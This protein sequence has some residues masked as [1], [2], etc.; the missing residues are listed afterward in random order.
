MSWILTVLGGLALG[1]VATLD[2]W[3]LGS[4]SMPGWSLP[5]LGAIFTAGLIVAEVLD[6]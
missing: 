3:L 6:R 5:L 2:A 4:P 1:V